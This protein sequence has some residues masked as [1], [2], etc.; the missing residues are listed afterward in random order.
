MPMALSR[1]SA[2]LLGSV[3]SLPD[4][5]LSASSL[6]SFRVCN[7]EARTRAT[8]N[9]KKTKK[10]Q[11]SKAAYPGLD[12]FASCHVRGAFLSDRWMIGIQCHGWILDQPV[13]VQGCVEPHHA[14]RKLLVPPLAKGLNV[15]EPMERGRVR[16]L[17]RD[18]EL[19]ESLCSAVGPLDGGWSL[20]DWQTWPCGESSK[21]PCGNDGAAGDHAALPAGI[22]GR[23]RW[24]LQ[25][26]YL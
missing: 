19:Q 7:C 22:D 18:Q 21:W 17:A 25:S 15:R 2:R 24:R 5:S 13:L 23:R 9:D 14:A 26:H 10:R 12:C 6:A 3:L 16:S 11:G 4:S 8:N 1:C 20:C